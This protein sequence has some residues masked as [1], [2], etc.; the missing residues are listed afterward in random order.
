MKFHEGEGGPEGRTRTALLLV[1]SVEGRR[2]ENYKIGSWCSPEKFCGDATA[3][4]KL[5][6]AGAGAGVGGAGGR[7]ARV[8]R[9]CFPRT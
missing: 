9:R 2:V 5:G 4:G 3:D 7:S 1:G 8:E 6:Y